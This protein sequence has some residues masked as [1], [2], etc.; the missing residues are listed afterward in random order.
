M[1]DCNGK[2]TPT[3][4]KAPLGNNPDG[5]PAKYQTKWSYASI[6]GMMMYF[7]YNFQPEI[8][9]YVHQCDH[10]TQNYRASHEYV[11]ICICLYLNNTH[12]KG[13]ILSPTGKL[14]V[15]CYVNSYFSGLF[16]YEDLHNRVC[17]RSGSG[18]VVTFSNFP[19]L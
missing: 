12:K 18:C 2:D 11:I 19:I 14:R 17:A 15:N 10:F 4:G 3:S 6:M 1:S 16:S 8:Q 13:L 7:A 9:F 5:N